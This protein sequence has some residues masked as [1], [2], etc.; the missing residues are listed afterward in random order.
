MTEELSTSP[1]SVLFG[2]DLFLSKRGT[3]PRKEKFR[4]RTLTLDEFVREI[5]KIVKKKNSC[6][7]DKSSKCHEGVDIPLEDQINKLFRYLLHI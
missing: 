5:P 1:N 3:I 4:E 2:H 6:N 7:H